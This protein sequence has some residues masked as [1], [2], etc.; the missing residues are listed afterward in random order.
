MLILFQLKEREYTRK[1]TPDREARWFDQK[2]IGLGT[3]QIRDSLK[4]LDVHQNI[5]LKRLCCK[6]R[7]F[8]DLST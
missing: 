2:V 3:K 7:L 1:T 6:V 5:L 4:Y 8:G